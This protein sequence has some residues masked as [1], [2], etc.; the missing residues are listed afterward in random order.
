[1]GLT[2]TEKDVLKEEVREAREARGRYV[3]LTAADMAVLK[4]AYDNWV[5]KTEE[6]GFVRIPFF[7]DLY[8]QAQGSL[9]YDETPSLSINQ[10]IY[11]WKAMKVKRVQKERGTNSLKAAIEGKKGDKVKIQ[12]EI[13]DMG[14]HKQLTYGS[15]YSYHKQ[16][17]LKTH[18][19]A[20]GGANQQVVFKLT[21]NQARKLALEVGKQYFISAKIKFIKGDGT[22]FLYYVS[23]AEKVGNKGDDFRLIENRGEERPEIGVMVGKTGRKATRMKI[24]L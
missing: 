21:E 24:L 7:A 15:R 22:V 8:L 4:A 1:M 19:T 3:I 16:Y 11:V 9:D 17:E 5:K 2:Q 6:K 23:K 10:Y 13:V 18:V 12:A 14:V 20:L